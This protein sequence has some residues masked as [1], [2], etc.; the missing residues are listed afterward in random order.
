MLLLIEFCSLE[1]LISDF[2]DSIQIVSFIV[3]F[4]PNQK[5]AQIWGNTHIE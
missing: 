3:V 2:A 5:F 1:I 4:F